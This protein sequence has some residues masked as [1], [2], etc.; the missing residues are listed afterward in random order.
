MQAL[1]MLPMEE[2]WY[3]DMMDWANGKDWNNETEY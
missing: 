1:E 2:E 3:N